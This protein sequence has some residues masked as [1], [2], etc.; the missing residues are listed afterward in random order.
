MH[1]C[2]AA[3]RRLKVGKHETVGDTAA[4]HR[5]CSGFVFTFDC[6]HE[7]IGIEGRGRLGI[8]IHRF[9]Q[10]IVSGMCNAFH[11]ADQLRFGIAIVLVVEAQPVR[12]TGISVGPAEL[13]ALPGPFNG[14]TQAVER[15]RTQLRQARD[16]A[17]D[18]IVAVVVESIPQA[19]GQARVTFA[20][21]WFGDIHPDIVPPDIYRINTQPI[22]AIK[23]AAVGQRKLPVVP[24]AGQHAIL[25]QTP[26]GQGVTLVRTAIVTGANT[27]RSYE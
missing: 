20:V 3:K 6:I 2:G 19:G 16:F 22:P 12:H 18:T 27:V 4:Q 15:I 25:R 21:G 13:H 24:V 11:Q 1:Q 7:G 9:A 23:I 5:H 14:K 8:G 26:F 17:R 10:N